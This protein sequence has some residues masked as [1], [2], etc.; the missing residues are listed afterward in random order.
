MADWTEVTARYRTPDDG[1]AWRKLL[2]CLAGLMGS[3]ALMILASSPDAVAWPVVIVGVIGASLFMNQLFLYQH[4]MGH[5]AFFEGRRTNDVVGQLVCIFMLTPFLEWTRSHALHHK[6]LGKLDHRSLGD[7]Y[8]MTL[9]E[10]RAWWRSQPDYDGG[11]QRAPSGVR[12]CEAEVSDLRGSTLVPSGR[13]WVVDDDA[14]GRAVLLQ[15][16]ASLARGAGAVIERGPGG[17]LR[18]A[19]EQ[20]SLSPWYALPSE[21]GRGWCPRLATGLR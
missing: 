6:N 15:H 21:G 7:I 17:L 14:R 2:G 4:D 18:A 19:E 13:A 5:M 20:F 3:W 9:D 12:L 8:V 16:L 11:P 1:I 10:W